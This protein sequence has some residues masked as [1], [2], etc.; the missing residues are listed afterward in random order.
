MEEIVN[1]RKRIT[2]HVRSS[3][4]VLFKKHNSHMGVPSKEYGKV[5]IRVSKLYQMKIPVKDFTEITRRHST[6]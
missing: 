5:G 1:V 6:G 4:N 2:S 3:L